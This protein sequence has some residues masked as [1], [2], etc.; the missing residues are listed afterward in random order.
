MKNGVKKGPLDWT[1]DADIAFLDLKDK[2]EQAP[3][4]HHYDPNLDTRVEIDASGTGVG[5]ILSQK[6][7]SSSPESGGKAVEL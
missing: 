3:L 4:L 5:G 1:P 2:F 7:T 6:V